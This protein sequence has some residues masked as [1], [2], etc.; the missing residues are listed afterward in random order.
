VHPPPPPPP[1]GGGRGGE[2]EQKPCQD[3]GFGQKKSSLSGG[4]VLTFGSV[5]DHNCF[6]RLDEVAASPN[7]RIE[8]VASEVGRAILL[9]REQVGEEVLLLAGSGAELAGD[10]L[11]HAEPRLIRTAAGL[12]GIVIGDRR[13]G[14]EQGLAVVTSTTLEQFG[15]AG[16]RV[17]GASRQTVGL[18]RCP[19]CEQG[20]RILSGDGDL[21]GDGQRLPE[22][23]GHA[24]ELVDGLLHVFDLGGEVL[25]VAHLEAELAAHIAHDDCEGVRANNASRGVDSIE[26]GRTVDAV[27]EAEPILELAVA[28]LESVE[29][30]AELDGHETAAAVIDRASRFDD[31]A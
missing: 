20:S 15:Q 25:G 10:R 29:I 5:A 21:V 22:L 23:S 1:P 16:H 12:M 2:G 26:V 17:E 3:A 19:T 27:E 30:G 13:K 24:E 7:Q 8:R 18:S 14:V 6:S 31:R 11:L 28:N 4:F 9:R